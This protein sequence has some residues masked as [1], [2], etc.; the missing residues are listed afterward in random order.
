MTPE[1]TILLTCCL[2]PIVL[3]LVVLGRLI[4]G[5]IWRKQVEKPT[6]TLTVTIAERVGCLGIYKGKEIPELVILDDGRKFEYVSL[7][8]KKP[9][10]IYVVDADIL[11]IKIDECLLFKQVPSPTDK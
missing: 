4:T 6:E 10:E 2:I 11:H 1:L 3:V 9:G 5:A 8:L 7:V